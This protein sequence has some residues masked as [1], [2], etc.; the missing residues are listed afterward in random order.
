MMAGLAQ[1]QAVP[2][3]PDMDEVT[4]FV[5][6]AQAD[7]EDAIERGGLQ[8]DQYR[9]P[10]RALSVVLGV[11]PTFVREMKAATAGPREPISSETM[12]ELGRT[13]LILV[14]REVGNLIRYR[15]RTLL[16]YLALAVFVM[17]GTSFG[18]GWFMRGEGPRQTAAGLRAAFAS[19]SQEAA[20]WLKLVEFNP[21]G[22]SCAVH[23]E[24]GRRVCNTSL[25]MDPVP[26][27]SR[28]S[29]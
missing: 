27:P 1:Q 29:Q 13:S 23:V 11:F 24:N 4:E 8:R 25:W 10:L 6:R 7:I 22:V 5:E 18:L 12:T 19:G 14:E 21:A 9:H 20:Q 17:A 3:R 26:A 16:L 2:L 28:R 15:L